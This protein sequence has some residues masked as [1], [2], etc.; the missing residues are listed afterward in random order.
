LNV[1]LKCRFLVRREG[2]DLG[3]KIAKA[4]SEVH[5][6]LV[7]CRCV[8]GEKVLEE[9]LHGVAKDD[10][11]GDLHHGGFH[12]KREEEALFFCLGNLRLEKF[13][14]RFFSHNGRIENFAY[15]QGDL[16]LEDSDVAVRAHKLDSYIR[17]LWNRDR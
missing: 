3:D 8:L 4:I 9:D 14:E 17:R 6:E 16:F 10:R 1:S 15:F 13:D 5:S 7:D 11:I 12:V 2:L